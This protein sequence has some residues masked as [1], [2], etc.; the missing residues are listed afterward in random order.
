M[1]K[2]MNYDNFAPTYARTRWAI[3]WI[4]SPLLT[5]ISK[6]PPKSIIIDIGCGTGDYVIALSNQFKNLKFFGLDSSQGMLDVA[7]KRG[8]QVKFS[9]GDADKKF[10][11]PNTFA[12]I[13]FCIDV[14][15]HLTDFSRFFNESYRILKEKGMLIIITDSEEDIRNRSLSQYFPEALDIELGRYPS[16]K[17]LCNK[18]KDAGLK[19]I[20][21]QKTSGYIEITDEFIEKVNHKCSSALRLISE[22]AHNTG[23][24]RLKQA[25][26]DGKKWLSRYTVL[27]FEKP[28]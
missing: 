13:L 19:K 18:A 2:A 11:Y 8:K 10:P 23:I 4:L 28:I 24:A 16:I 7:R 20:T 25:K 22:D 27:R 14:V 5:T 9:I 17:E 6:L 26:L 15:H 3:P 12:D 1:G 21:R